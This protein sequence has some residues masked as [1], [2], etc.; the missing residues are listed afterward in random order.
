MHFM[1]KPV[2]LLFI[3]IVP[4]GGEHKG[5][6]KLGISIEGTNAR[7]NVSKIE[8][9]GFPTDDNLFPNKLGTIWKVIINDPVEFYS[10]LV[11][12]S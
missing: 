1:V 12:E 2:L 6:G 3:N 5:P 8:I 4:F 7:H 10:I 9:K 11:R